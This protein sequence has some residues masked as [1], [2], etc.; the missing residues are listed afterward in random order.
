MIT[1]MISDAHGPGE[2][3][4]AVQHVL[5]RLLQDARRQGVEAQVRDKRPAPH[6]LHSA[7]VI[8]VGHNAESLA[9][10]W[11]GTVQWIWP[12]RLRPKHPRKNW[13]VGVIR[14]ET[15]APP[16]GHGVLRIQTCKAGGKGGQHVNK[17]ESA[18]RVTDTASGLSVKIAR[19]RSQHA[20][21]RLALA[22]LA[23]KQAAR[24][25]SLQGQQA[26]T[27]HRQHWQVEKGGAVKVF[28]GDDF[29]EKTAPHR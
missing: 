17:T 2:C 12:S 25:D 20:N 8:L 18:V 7:V 28:A 24:H 26:Y 3:Q 10:Q 14:L 16:V 6:G 11:Q 29:V 27:R 21:K 9:E 23:D 1:L 4:L 13:F 19:E 22:A 15:P 5:E